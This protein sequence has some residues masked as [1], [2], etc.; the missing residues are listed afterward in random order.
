MPDTIP[1]PLLKAQKLL[2]KATTLADLA[3]ARAVLGKQ[4]RTPPVQQSS[5]YQHYYEE[6]SQT[7][8]HPD[9]SDTNPYTSFFIT[10]MDYPA[11]LIAPFVT[12]HSPFPTCFAHIS[13]MEHFV[14][15]YIGSNSISLYDKYTIFKRTTINLISHRALQALQN[16]F[17]QE[18][19]ELAE[20]AEDEPCYFLHLGMQS[21][22]RAN[23]LADCLGVGYASHG[24]EQAALFTILLQKFNTPEKIQLLQDTAEEESQKSIYIE[25][26]VMPFLEFCHS[27]KH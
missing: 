6:C 12:L 3:Q 24:E 14:R 10:G 7:H 15:S 5:L 22:I 21:W 16:V 13:K 4:Q 20:C 27:T 18:Q 8:P 11:S 17:T 9:N 26:A 23:M 19:K 1:P 25:Y 2:D